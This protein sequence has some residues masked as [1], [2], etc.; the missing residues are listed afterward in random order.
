M[1]FGSRLD[2]SKGEI[3][4][5]AGNCLSGGFLCEQPLFFLKI[6]IKKISTKILG[7]PPHGE[8]KGRNSPSDLGGDYVEE[9][10]TGTL[11]G[12]IV[13]VFSRAQI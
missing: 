12:D 9:S 11:G 2:E 5:V 7:R 10:V 13:G 6:M 1:A 4:Q 3:T 8:L